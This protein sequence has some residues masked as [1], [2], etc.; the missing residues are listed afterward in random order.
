VLTRLRIKN[1]KAWSDTGDIRL[2]PIT[3]LFGG[4]STRTFWSLRIDNTTTLLRAVSQRAQQ[5]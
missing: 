2:A 5:N 3:V 4:S 1:F